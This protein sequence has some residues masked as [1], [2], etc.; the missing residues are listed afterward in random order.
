M[1]SALCRSVTDGGA[2]AVRRYQWERIQALLPAEFDAAWQAADG[3][4]G[5]FDQRH[6]AAFTLALQSLPAEPTVVEIGSYLGRS[7]VFQAQILA[8]LGRG[9]GITAI[10]PHTG[11]RQHLEMLGIEELPTWDMFCY[12]VRG[13]DPDGL[14]DMVRATSIEAA[15]EWDG[16]EIDLL[17]IDGWHSYDAVRED[18]EH[19]LPHLSA[20]GIVVF[21][22]YGYYA[23]DVARAV[24]ELAEAGLFTPWGVNAR[25]MIGGRRS[26]PS[27]PLDQL[28]TIV[29]S[30]VMR[31]LASVKARISA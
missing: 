15:R 7:A 17:Y 10:D 21:D 2:A 9:G 6:A 22:D 30:S 27:A 14:V 8:A 12:F 24:D 28:L 31:R 26:A 25:Q 3:V 4:P 5:W 13:L 1:L 19:W 11:D 23:D 16:R 29:D 18:G 20:D